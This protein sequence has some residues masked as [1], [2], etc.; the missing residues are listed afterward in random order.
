M[1]SRAPSRMQRNTEL[2]TYHDHLHI[3][4]TASVTIDAE[5]HDVTKSRDRV[6]WATP[7][8]LAAQ[9]NLY[10]NC[11]TATVDKVLLGKFQA[12]CVSKITNQ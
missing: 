9:F 11:A 8:H 10:G 3:T 4:A 12:T 1:E 6:G 7:G 2:N 5:L